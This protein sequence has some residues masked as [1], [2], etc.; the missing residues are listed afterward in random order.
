MKVLHLAL[1]NLRQPALCDALASLGEYREID[2]IRE[3]RE[4]G[5]AGLKRDLINSHGK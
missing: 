4:K 1:N 5:R 2:W 3:E